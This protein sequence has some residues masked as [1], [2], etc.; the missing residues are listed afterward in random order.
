MIRNYW[1]ITLRD[2]D[3]VEKTGHISHLRNKWNI[4][5]VMFFK[6]SIENLL[7][8]LSDKLNEGIVD[9]NEKLE[10]AIWKFE[11]LNKINAIKGNYLKLLIALKYQPELNDLKRF[12]QKY[13]WK[14]LKIQKSSIVDVYIQRLKE[15]T[16]IEIK[17]NEDIERVRKDLE[18]RNDK[19]TENFPSKEQQPGERIYLMG[20]ALGVFSKL[21]LP[22]NPEITVMEF[23]EAKNK[24]MHMNKKV[25]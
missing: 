6:K 2:Y 1:D 25:A 15:L 9:D 24:V 12:Y 18:F 5:P 20:F 23:I 17:T 22:F 10:N 16:G 14:R 4:V 19:Y 13:T 3:I 21:N 7:Q 11:S 8:I